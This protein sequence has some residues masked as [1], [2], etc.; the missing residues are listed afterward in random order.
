MDQNMKDFLSDMRTRVPINRFKLPEECAAQS[1]LCQEIGD[2][3]IQ[4]K[5]D[6]NGAKDAL[7]LLE[8]TLMG[9]IRATPGAY[10]V[11]KLTEGTVNAAIIRQP[12]YQEAQKVFRE[13]EKEYGFLQ[14]IQESVAQRKSQLGNLTDQFVHEFYSNADIRSCHADEGRVQ[15]AQGQV[16]EDQIVS[17]R[18]ERAQERE[19]E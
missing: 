2:K 10:A 18:K 14:I 11:D 16:T 7:K 12:A 9:K 3:V 4:A 5:D 8:S 15:K 17:R 19:Q 13:A 6:V 1:V